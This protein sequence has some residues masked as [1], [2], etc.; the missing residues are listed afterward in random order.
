MPS[1]PLLDPADTSSTLIRPRRGP[2]THSPSLLS[3][4][5]PLKEVLVDSCH[6]LVLFY[7]FGEISIRKPALPII[8]TIPTHLHPPP[9]S[10]N[11]L[12]AHRLDCPNNTTSSSNQPHPRTKADRCL[13]AATPSPIATH[14]FAQDLAVSSLVTSAL[15]SSTVATAQGRGTEKTPGSPR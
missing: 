8:P 4:L 2:S 15:K 1:S 7:L 12:I 10:V 14:T 13:S 5:P 3:N 9:L 11:E 6:S